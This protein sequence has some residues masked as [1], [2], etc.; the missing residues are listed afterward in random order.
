LEEGSISLRDA[1]HGL[2]PWSDS[3]RSVDMPENGE[4]TMENNHCP[5]SNFVYPFKFE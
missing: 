1:C 4:F 5:G 3:N 2:K